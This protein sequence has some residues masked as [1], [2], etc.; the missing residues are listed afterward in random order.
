M[1]VLVTGAA[2]QL[3]QSLVALL[4]GYNLFAVTR[5]ELDITCEDNIAAIVEKVR[6]HVIINCAAYTNVE[7]AEADEHTAFDVN[8]TA[9]AGLAKVANKFDIVVIHLS[10]DYVFDGKKGPFQE[11]SIPNPIN[12][13][14]KSKAQG[15][16]IL[17]SKCNKYII[18]RTSWLFSEYGNNFVK[19]MIKLAK[20]RDLLEVVND[21][22]GHPT[23]A[24]DVARFIES[25]LAKLDAEPNFENWGYYHFA[26]EP[27]V[28]RY[29]FSQTIFELA[30]EHKIL[31]SIPHVKA[32]D[33]ASFASRAQRPKHIQLAMNKLVTF[34][35]NL[36]KWRLGLINAI[37]ASSPTESL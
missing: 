27:N 5:N 18:I 22:H 33:S 31:E 36:P 8:A 17:A 28:T 12:V 29:E 11:N 37:K 3:G 7:R 15:E 13:Y 24:G 10:T 6:P 35:V 4:K 30:I 19:T 26:G 16:A 1:N 20:E 2:G 32:I 34:D 14:G 23:Y 25:I 9:L 21:Q